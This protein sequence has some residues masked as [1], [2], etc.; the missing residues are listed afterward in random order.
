MA[1]EL[2]FVTVPEDGDKGNIF[3]PL[4]VELYEKFNNHNHDGANSESITDSGV[5]KGTVTIPSS[6]WAANSTLPGY[7]QT[8][9]TPT[10]FSIDSS[11]PYF[12]VLSGEHIGK[13]IHP[14]IERISSTSI[15][16]YVNDSSLELRAIFL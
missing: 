10:G 8:I 15:R 5:Q 2:E 1:R 3:F 16:V 11:S 7:N 13:R 9:T 6:G 4:I 12:V 14:S